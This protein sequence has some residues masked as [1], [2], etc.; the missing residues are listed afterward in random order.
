[1]MAVGQ[2]LTTSTGGKEFNTVVQMLSLIR[3][4]IAQTQQC[5]DH[6]LS[7]LYS[8]LLQKE[9]IRWLMLFNVQS[10]VQEA[11]HITSL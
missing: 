5:D 9:E 3:V 8:F 2:F 10:S 6:F 4:I 11:D 7:V 1:M